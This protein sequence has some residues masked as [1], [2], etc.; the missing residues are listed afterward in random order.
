MSLCECMVGATDIRYI[1]NLWYL[2]CVCGKPLAMFV[3]D[4]FI[5]AS[6]IRLVTLDM[7]R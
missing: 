7:L 1:P 2:S 5:N 3:G 4:P 6:Q